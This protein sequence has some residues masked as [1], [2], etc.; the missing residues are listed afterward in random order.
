[1]TG[2][3]PEI[4]ISPFIDHSLLT[5]T[6]TLEEASKFCTDADKFRFPSVCVYPYYVKQISEFLHTKHPKASTVIGF[7]TGLT[8]GNTKLYEAQEAADN[9]A[10]EL[11][12]MINLSHIKTGQ[13]NKIYREIAEI[14]EETGKTVKAIL[15]M[16]LLTEA[17]KRLVTEILMDAGAAFI[18]TNTGWYGGATVADVQLLKEITKNNLGIKA[19]G[20]I[21]TYEQA[22]NLVLAGATRLGTSRGLELIY[23]QNNQ[24]E[25]K[26]KNQN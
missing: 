11:D 1:M 20:G 25:L 3:Q 14:C 26:S 9:G 19:A 2:E 12:V 5:I 7:P 24:S 23:Q 22:A 21:K 16:A 4:D 17:E 15:E 10:S 6:A 13:T 8:T 18:V